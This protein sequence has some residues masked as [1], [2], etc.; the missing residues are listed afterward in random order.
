MHLLEYF[1]VLDLDAGR[2]GRTLGRHV[3]VLVAKPV[4]VV[5]APAAH[6]LPG[7]VGRNLDYCESLL[8]EATELVQQSPDLLPQ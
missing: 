8:A 4:A 2:L 6:V 3:R 7:H 1:P 5:E